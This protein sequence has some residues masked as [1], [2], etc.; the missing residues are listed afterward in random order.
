M[1]NL[2]IELCSK[3]NEVPECFLELYGGSINEIFYRCP[4]C[5]RESRHIKGI[6]QKPKAIEDW[7]QLQKKL[8]KS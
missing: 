8:S 7:N 3:C 1:E 2:N 6:N 5:R 4:C